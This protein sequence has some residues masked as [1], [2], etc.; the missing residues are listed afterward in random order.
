MKQLLTKLYYWSFLVMI[1]VTLVGGGYLY[2]LYCVDGTLINRPYSNYSTEVKTDK[3]VYKQGEMIL[4]T[5]Y[6]CLNRKLSTPLIRHWSFVDGLVYATPETEIAPMN[7]LGCNNRTSTITEIPKNLPT[8]EYYL[9]GSLQVK[10]NSVRTIE[11][12]RKTNKF[13]VIGNTPENEEEEIFN[14]IK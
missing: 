14:K 9:S 11:Y 5:W 7:E 3:L 10:I 1:S 13:T 6:R 2:F 4:G 8:G 12:P